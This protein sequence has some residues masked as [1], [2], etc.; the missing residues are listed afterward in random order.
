[1][2]DLSLRG[3]YD[4]AAR[5]LRVSRPADARDVCLRIL[6]SFPRH[7]ATYG[8]L[9]HAYARL[10]RRGEATNLFS[11]VLAVDP[12]SLSAHT[13]L[14]A[15]HERRAELDR[16]LWHYQLACELAPGDPDARAGFLR[17]S[18]LAA[19]QAPR[20]VQLSRAGLARA[21]AR[22][23]LYDLAAREYRVLLERE[24]ARYDLRVGLA[25]ALWRAR[26]SEEAASVCQALLTELPNCLKAGLILGQV[27]LGTDR[28]AFGRTLLQ[29]AQALDPDNAVAQEL[30]G[31]RSPLPPRAARLPFREE[32]APPLDLDYLL[33]S[34]DLADEEVP[35]VMTSSPSLPAAD[36]RGPA[37]R[38]E[39][40]RAPQASVA[41][42]GAS[43]ADEGASVADEVASRA[44][45]DAAWAAWRPGQPIG[46]ATPAVEEPGSAQGPAGPGEPDESERTS[47]EAMT[48]IDVQR[49]Y[50]T[51]HPED[52][53]ARLDLAQRFRDD[54]S[55]Y[56]A[57]EQY[58]WLVNNDVLLLPQAID[59]LEFLDRM[60]PRTAELHD[61]LAEARFRESRRP[62]SSS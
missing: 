27:W 53:R 14:G 30:F 44:E 57:I 61:L 47:W 32:D 21:Y 36:S 16:S 45:D 50:V 12:E 17:V 41:D 1:M 15:V 59:D 9:G 39:P 28:D 40:R 55:L 24:P 23:R 56:E 52:A 49:K 2:A 35:P 43:V 18:G 31:E 8:L 11:R 22:A 6:E 10:G 62:S 20:R 19:G 29:R 48:L 3:Q 7:V 54:G 26:Q 51:E 13:G 60:Y 58:R 38:H 37:V 46:D 34:D 25:E 4:E 33:D 5:L 42:E